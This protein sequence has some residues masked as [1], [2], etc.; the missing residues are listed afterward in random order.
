MSWEGKVTMTDQEKVAEAL[1]TGKDVWIEYQNELHASTRKNM[2]LPVRASIERADEDK[3]WFIIST[4]AGTKCY[5]YTGIKRIETYPF[6]QEKQAKMELLAEI[7][8]SVYTKEFDK[9]M[10]FLE[11]E[12]I[13]TKV[14]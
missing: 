3:D 1:R 12:G 2:E 7:E 6:N 9:I 11:K 5:K 13:I 10:N 4:V 8:E 14:D